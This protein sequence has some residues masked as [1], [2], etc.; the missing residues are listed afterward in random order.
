[1]YSRVPLF[2]L[3]F[4][5]GSFLFPHLTHASTIPFFGP[6]VPSVTQTGVPGSDVCA[7]GWG[8]L[9]LVVNNIIRVLIS[10]AIVFMLPIFLTYAGFLFVANPGNPGNISK[11]R[12][13][14]INAIG[15]IIIALAAWLLVDALMAVLYKGPS[16]GMKAWSDIV[17]GNSSLYCLPVAVPLPSVPGGGAGSTPGAPGG[18][19]AQCPATNRACSPLALQSVGFNLMQANVMS[20]IAITESGGD[21]SKPP[22]NLTHPNERPISTACGLFQI[23]K[24]NWDAYAS[25]SCADFSKCTNPACNT[26]VAYILVSHHGYG[27]WTCLG[28]NKNAPACVSTYGG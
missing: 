10:I 5:I 7:L 22:Y 17:L 6:I 19:A 3:L 26:Q 27:D 8:A 2:V 4:A 11:A 28:C 24:T 9:I 12:G 20:C 18:A 13:V 1:M 23:T 16:G 15:G 14:L 25:G 21:P